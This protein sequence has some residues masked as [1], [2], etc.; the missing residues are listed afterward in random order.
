MK[1]KKK[2]GHFFFKYKFGRNARPDRSPPKDIITF[3][4]LTYIRQIYE[5]LNIQECPG[6]TA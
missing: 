5:P 4:L 1:K 2:N 6:K 3:A